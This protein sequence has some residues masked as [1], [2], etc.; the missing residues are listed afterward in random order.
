MGQETLNAIGKKYGKWTVLSKAIPPI[1]YVSGKSRSAWNCQC[2]CG[3]L[4]VLLSSKLSD[5]KIGGCWK[6]WGHR[7]GKQRNLER[8]GSRG[9]GSRKKSSEASVCR[10]NK[11]EGLV[12]TRIGSRII[13]A[14]DASGAEKS[15]R[16][17]VRCDC[18]GIYELGL[19]G[20]L[21]NQSNSCRRCSKPKTGALCHYLRKI[22]DSAKNRGLKIDEDSINEEY[23]LSIFSGKCAL[24]GVEISLGSPGHIGYLT[25]TASLDRKDSSKGYTKGNVQWVHKSVNFMKRDMDQPLFID[26]CAK[27]A[28]NCCAS[29]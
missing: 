11:A 19:Y 27:I 24:S 14:V 26:F 10:K 1:V 20:L 22:G 23:L 6:C 21:R 3:T 16:A 9:K 29:N 4:K 17:L 7:T 28:K 25:R 13:T 18:G 5:K 2:D 8:L 12:G 15:W